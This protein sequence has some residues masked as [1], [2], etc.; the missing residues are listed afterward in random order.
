MLMIAEWLN[1]DT[2][3]EEMSATIK[4]TE[5]EVKK[6]S[7]HGKM[8]SRYQMKKARFLNSM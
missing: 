4:N 1:F 3:P 5:V 6:I 7:W 8:V 2:H